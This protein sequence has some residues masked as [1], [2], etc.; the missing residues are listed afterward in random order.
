VTIG[1]IREIRIRPI[2]SVS[3]FTGLSGGVGAT[4]FSIFTALL[5]ELLKLKVWNETS[6]VVK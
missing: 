1:T 5:P 4:V 2:V 6:E 3:Q